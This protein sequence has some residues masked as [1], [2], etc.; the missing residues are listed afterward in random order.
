MDDGLLK[1]FRNLVERDKVRFYQK[2]LVFF[3]FLVVAT[4]FWFL[5]ALN[6]D[7]TSDIQY[8]VRYTNLPKGKVLINQL[9]ENLT[10]KVTGHGYTLLKH[11]LSRKLLPI[12]FDVN[13]FILSSI[14]DTVNQKFYVLSRV[15]H[16][17]ITNQLSSEIEIQEI[18][19]DSIIFVFSDVTSRRLAVKP[20]LNIEFEKQFMVKGAITC[21][22][23]SVDVEGPQSLLDTMQYAYTQAVS[24]AKVKENQS[25][26]V[27]FEEFDQVYYSEKK[28][29]VDIPVEQFTET[30]LKVP[31]AAANVP[32]G[33]T[34]KLFP[35]EITVSY[36]VALSDYEKIKP[37]HFMATADYL[38][39][40]NGNPQKLRIQVGRMPEHIVFIRHY[41]ES[42]DYIIEK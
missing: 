8:P 12:I 40:E 23:D 24:I 29:T 15:A 38:L 2:L 16:S 25:K 1:Q 6:R 7:Y 20:V 33:L 21:I 26:T 37:Q 9:P 34:L 17:K 4:I 28:V 14:E 18:L 42:V 11:R 32:E 35:A 5:S 39:L 30:S 3:F 36:M 27:G 10:L 22:P 13:S 19:P 41:P 31:I